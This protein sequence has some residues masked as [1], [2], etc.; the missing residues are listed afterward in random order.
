M[1]SSY[2]SWIFVEIFMVNDNISAPDLIGSA[3][4]CRW[5]GS[6]TL[7]FGSNHFNTLY[8]MRSKKISRFWVRM[9]FVATI[10]IKVDGNTGTV[11]LVRALEIV[12]TKKGRFQVKSCISHLS[13]VFFISKALYL[14]FLKPCISCIISS[15]FS[16]PK[17]CISYRLSPS[18][19]ASKAL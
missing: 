18:I 7:T 1:Y 10:A 2:S 14:L 15:V 13:H 11:C 6:I 12:Y 4:F 17:P 3:S 16:Y 19:S 5:S 8:S 9:E